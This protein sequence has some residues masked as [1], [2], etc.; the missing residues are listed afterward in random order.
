MERGTQSFRVHI[1]VDCMGSARV[2]WRTWLERLPSAWRATSSS[3][4]GHVEDQMAKN[5]YTV[6]VGDIE[7]LCSLLNSLR[8]LE[9]VFDAY[10]VTPS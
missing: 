1:A 7:E 8:N 6:E 2:C 10:R 4:A 5:W 9:S 3:T